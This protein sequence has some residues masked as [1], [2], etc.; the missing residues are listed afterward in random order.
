MNWPG[1]DR[2]L[3]NV[4]V[5]MA[6]FNGG[7]F[8]GE[9]LDSIARQTLLPAELVVSD[10]G[11]E[12]DTLAIIA[13]FA[14]RAPFPVR[15]LPA[16]PR[17]GFADNFL[18]AAE[19]CS[20]DAIVFADQDDVW[21]PEKVACGLERLVGDG[22]LLSLHWLD[23][24]DEA[25][26]PIGLNRQGITADAVFDALQLPP[27]H[28]VWGNTMMFRR[29]LLSV[30][31]PAQRPRQPGYDR[32][33]SHD[34]W[35]HVLAA[36]LG[37]ISHIAAPLISYRQHGENVFGVTAAT[38]QGRLKQWVASPVPDLRDRHEFADRMASL[39]ARASG[40]G[41][42]TSRQ[43][44]QRASIRF[45]Q[46]RDLLGLRL[47]TY[48]EVSFRKRL[49]ACIAHARRAPEAGLGAVLRAGLK[50]AVLGAAGLSRQ[51]DAGPP[52]TP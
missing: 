20:G 26:R 13:A 46:R 33:L 28:S 4:S 3:P 9:Q 19:H 48:Q 5:A 30:A 7:R 31:P 15:V 50:D 43:P 34:H 25:L 38:V 51:I 16:H 8:L 14:S 27:H 1:I 35:I 23:V 24:T 40:G 10:D 29:E 22:S 49:A 36:S 47:A 45:A 37:R 18:H 6:T 52:S 17:L 39:L 32:P 2:A 44:A 41:G 11:S 21:S 12:D 42:P